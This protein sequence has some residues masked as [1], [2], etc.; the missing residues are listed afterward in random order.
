MR[1]DSLS[2]SYHFFSNVGMILRFYL[3]VLYYVCI[4]VCVCVCVCVCM[5][6]CVG[7]SMFAFQMLIT[8]YKHFELCIEH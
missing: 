1:I 6:V 8:N 2:T 3:Y 5:C 7:V 4:L